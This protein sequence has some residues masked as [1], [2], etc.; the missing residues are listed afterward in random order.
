M[1]AG[2]KTSMVPESPELLCNDERLPSPVPA[3]A[4]LPLLQLDAII[5]GNKAN[6]RTLRRTQRDPTGEG[7]VR[8]LQP[9]RQKPRVAVG[10][11]PMRPPPRP[12]TLKVLQNPLRLSVTFHATYGRSITPAEEYN[13]GVNILYDH[14]TAYHMQRICDALV[15]AEPSNLWLQ[16]L[17]NLAVDNTLVPLL[18]TN[19]NKLYA[20]GHIAAIGISFA[21]GN[22]SEEQFDE[23]PLADLR[24]AVWVCFMDNGWSTTLRTKLKPWGVPL[25]GDDHL[26]PAHPFNNQNDATD[27]LQ[28]YIHGASVWFTVPPRLGMSLVK[29]RLECMHEEKEEGEKGRNLEVVHQFIVQFRKRFEDL[30]KRLQQLTLEID[31]AF[32]DVGCTGVLGIK[33]LCGNYNCL[34]NHARGSGNELPVFQMNL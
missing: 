20:V 14:C 17:K 11:P 7:E 32:D 18:M 4:P 10:P 21:P 25:Q 33:C 26:C 22:V 13:F 24:Y 9:A 23:N 12:Y 30:R 2:N 5:D 15:K 34:L 16:C 3:P 29:G 19:S 1:N 31:N 6:T 8:S 28:Y 27:P